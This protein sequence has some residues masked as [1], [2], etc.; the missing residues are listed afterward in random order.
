MN[1]LKENLFVNKKLF[2]VIVLTI[3]LVMPIFV[4][5]ETKA[6]IVP[7]SIF[8]FLDI[9]SERVS[10]FFTFD[11]EKK[12]QKTLKYS[13]ERLAEIEEEKGNPEAVEKI[14]KNY[15]YGL[16]LAIKQSQ[17][18]K[19]KGKSEEL[20]NTIT[21]ATKKHQ[22]TLARV[23][24]LVPDNAKEAI[25]HARI[26][27][28]KG[29]EEA[30]KQIIDLK[31]EVAELKEEIEKLKEEKNEEEK[32]QEDQPEEVKELKQQVEELSKKKVEVEIE[33]EDE[34]E[35]VVQSVISFFKKE[36]ETKKVEFV[37]MTFTSPDGYFTNEKMFFNPMLNKK[38]IDILV[39]RGWEITDSLLSNPISFGTIQESDDKAEST[40]TDNNK[41]LRITKVSVNSTLTSV[42]VEWETNKPAQSK[43]FFSGG[44][45]SLKVISSQSGLSTRHLVNVTSLTSGT[46]YSYEIEA[47][48]D[49][50]VTKKQGTF[51]TEEDLFVIS[52][53][54]DKTSVPASGY[55]QI[56][57]MIKIFKN[58]ENQKE[59]IYMTSPDLLQGC[60]QITNNGGSSTSWFTNCYYTPKTVV[61]TN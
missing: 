44:S 5:A 14:I 8:Y 46:I 13:E 58:G 32:A 9:A 24:D 36:P 19:D 54:P 17:K 57:F 21:E 40:D 11:F 48:A 27:S 35:S 60:R 16:A 43:I 55:H 10:L 18:T 59:T 37:K 41:S 51:T 33:D 26:V 6:G 23:Y 39:D 49:K 29:Q 42:N 47:I 2:L 28:V 45:L 1:W 15:E 61:H 20:L 3:I 4:S 30:T 25:E 38:Q 12:V 52:V 50:E 34:P 7:S 53:Q 22:E 31:K 56:R